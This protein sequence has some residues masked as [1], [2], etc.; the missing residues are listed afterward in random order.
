MNKRIAFLAIGIV[1]VLPLSGAFAQAEI[2]VKPTTEEVSQKRAEIQTRREELKTT[3]EEKRAE[4]QTRKEE[5]KAEMEELKA[6]R[7]QNREQW[8]KNVQTRIDTR[9][10]RYE[11]NQA[12]Y[13]KVYSNMQSRLQKLSEMLAKKGGNVTQLNADLV[14]LGELIKKLDTDYASFITGLKETES[15]TCGQSDGEFKKQLGEARN[16][17]PLIKEDR[18]AIKNFYQTTIKKD[19]QTIRQT[20]AAANPQDADD[21]DTKVEETEKTT[22]SSGFNSPNPSL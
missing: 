18:L 20:I 21:T 9:V 13:Q 19:L 8:C 7:K 5:M 15:V 11:N 17:I 14:K 10:N 3:A 2:A 4:I 16:V 1:A 12:M 22:K 6:Q